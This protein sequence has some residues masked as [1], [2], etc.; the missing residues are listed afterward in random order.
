MAL[1]DFIRSHHRE[2]I[3]E[4]ERFARTLI[5]PNAHMTPAELRDHAAEMLTA[6]VEDLAVAQSDTNSRRNR[7]A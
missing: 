6:I 2:I 7:A 1:S 5:P 3:Q 4:F